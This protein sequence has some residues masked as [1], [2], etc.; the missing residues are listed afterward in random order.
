MSR[1]VSDLSSMFK[2]LI[3]LSKSPECELLIIP[4]RE[5]NISSKDFVPI[6]GIISCK[7]I[8]GLWVLGNP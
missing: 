5:E 1:L 8:Q 2:F 4:K 6:P 3:L 7:G